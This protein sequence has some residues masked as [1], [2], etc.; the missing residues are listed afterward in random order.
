MNLASVA[1]RIT[2]VAFAGVAAILIGLAARPAMAQISLGSPNDPPRIALMLGAF[3]IVPSPHKDSAA[4]ADFGLEYRFGDVLYAFSPFVGAFG[5]SDGAGYA[6]FGF[7]FDVNFGPDWVLTPN[8]SAGVFERGSG[9]KLGSWWEFRTGAELDYKLTNGSRVGV[10][11]HHISN[12]GLTKQNP[13]EE[14]AV[15][16]YTIPFH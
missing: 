1:R 11:V 7:G 2:P 10:A 9:T 16:V 4:A 12:A 3:D 8:G 13:G 6:Y 15:L 5:T 14:S